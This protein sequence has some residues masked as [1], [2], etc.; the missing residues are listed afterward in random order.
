M[1]YQADARQHWFDAYAK[2][3]AAAER[4]LTF[5]G[6]LMGQ[7]AYNRSSLQV[8]YT[9][10]VG[11]IW[12]RYTASPPLPAPHLPSPPTKVSVPVLLFRRLLDGAGFV[13]SLPLLAEF[14]P[15]TAA[16]VAKTLKMSEADFS[17]LL[18]LEDEMPSRTTSRQQYVDAVAR[19]LLLEQVRVRVRA[20]VR[21]GVWVRVRARARV[22]VRVRA[23]ARARVS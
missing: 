20:R 23:R 15:T 3:S 4:V 10:D 21:V 17:S 2:R 9:R 18:E 6:W 5:A 7:S 14:D 1:P 19:R 11:E 22:R 13:P 12:A 16:G 8:R